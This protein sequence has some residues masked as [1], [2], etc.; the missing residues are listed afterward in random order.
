MTLG[1]RSTSPLF[2]LLVISLLVVFSTYTTAN[3]LNKENTNRLTS[4]LSNS[5][6]QPEFLSPEQAFK[7]QAWVEGSQVFVLWDIA[8]NYYLYQD[9]LKIELA[10]NSSLTLEK[11]EFPPALSH[12]DEY[13]G[14]TQVYYN[15]VELTGLL[16][17]KTQNN[18]LNLT[19]HYQGCADA[20]LC[21]P[22]QKQTLQ[23]N[24]AKL[25]TNAE[26]RT[27]VNNHLNSSAT[28]TPPAPPASTSNQL[29]NLLGS[30]KIWL[31]LGLFFIAGLGLTFTPCVLPMLP[32][33]STI[34]VGKGTGNEKQ[35]KTRGLLLSAAYVLAL[36]AYSNSQ[37]VCSF[38]PD[39]L[40]CLGTAATHL[41][42]PASASSTTA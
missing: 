11:T 39:T 15:Q 29:T 27:Q 32:I 33:L 23:V 34:I 20:G 28:S 26:P 9:K 25:D 4:W 14:I 10:D 21:Y 13:F 5:S 8:P 7:A 30:G 3:P 41:V 35:P 42:R 31:T 19:I 18:Q 1:K 6:S 38:S 40:W 24:L 16:S 22:P 2:F 12:E 37:P 17:G 36:A